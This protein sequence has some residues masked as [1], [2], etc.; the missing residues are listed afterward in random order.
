MGEVYRADDLKLDQA[1]AL[2]FLPEALAKHPDGLA[3]FHSEVRLARQI[4]HPNVCRVHD[5]GEVDG[6][7]FLSMEYVDGEDLAS[8]L[9]RIGRLPKDKALVIA[10]ELCAGLQAAHDRGVLHRDLK[11][12]NVMIDGQGSV[13]IT[14]FGLASIAGAWNEADSMSGTPAYM[15]PE[16]LG[17]FP[18]SV[19]SDIYALGLVLYEMVTGRKAFEASSLL[20]WIQKHQDEEPPHPSAVAA[21]I[22]PALEATILRCL[23]K[24]PA[25]R[26]T[27]ALAVAA[28]LPG[29]DPLAA[30]LAAGQTPS[31]G[32][33]AA[34]GD[35]GGLK[36]AVAW[37]CLL[38][39]LAGIF[40]FV[41][42]NSQQ[43]L[44][45]RANLDKPPQVLEDRARTI[46]EMAGW[47]GPVTQRAQGF[48]TNSAWLS[49]VRRTDSSPDRW[50]RLAESRPAE[51]H[52]WLRQSRET[53][54][55]DQAFALGRVG[56]E[57]PPLSEAGMTRVLLDSQ[58]RL[59][60]FNVVPPRYDD[61][62]RVAPPPDWSQFFRE[63][64]LDLAA[65]QSIPSFSTPSA[66]ADER[67]AWTGR[68]PDNPD[69]EIQIEAASFRGRPVRFSIVEPWSKPS[70]GTTP[71]KRAQ[72]VQ[73]V[74]SLIIVFVVL[75]G[76]LLVALRNLRL[77]RADRSSAL[78]LAFVVFFA[79]V[80]SFLVGA[81]HLPDATEEINLFLQ[82][83]AVAL[84][85]WSV[86]WFLYL[87]LEPYVRRAW[88]ETLISW[89]RLMSG[90]YRDPLV[91]RDILIGGVFGTVM[92]VAALLTHVAPVWLGQ[93]PPIPA[94]VP[95][96]TL[97]GGSKAMSVLFMNLANSVFLPVLL[98]SSIVI[99][100]LILRKKFLAISGTL[101]LIV[102]PTLA[103]ESDP[104][105]KIHTTFIL[106][107]TMFVLLRFGVLSLIAG[108]I[109]SS[110]IAQY[111]M[112][113][114]MSKW[115][116]GSAL[117]IL[118]LQVALLVYGFWISLAGRPALK[119]GPLED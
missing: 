41:Q 68:Y 55:P 91:G 104:A 47:D 98:L 28:S 15:S 70:P 82:A 6:Q 24:D 101:L 35:V 66:F 2:K 37:T 110:T 53:M 90:R 3:N 60:A 45:G 99:L 107:A 57:N 67:V 54:S 108:M 16:Q 51:Y 18:A 118:A 84:L 87:A 38:A 12:A 14:D 10:R 93:P 43:A 112:S 100:R 103:G 59:V 75:L 13:R 116:T 73:T 97:L 34:A 96:D 31:P 1:V 22:D 89:T 78:K 36:P 58:G 29:G 20:E 71:S 46:L 76:G 30:A 117:F 56:Y 113:F 92:F 95:Q 21:D 39:A 111:P 4:T 83:V 79:F 64:G 109:G 40:L 106:T 69:V 9:R 19:R 11:P 23:D 105:N 81:D 102:L 42:L 72:T 5:I 49:H 7:H 48:R 63:A 61:S 17:G 27:S 77:G 26:P 114:D 8:L 50:E 62:V 52:Y 65:F 85:N 25:K 44:F 74:I 86:I 119:T 33:V 115:Y 80:L 88:P 94:G 32:M